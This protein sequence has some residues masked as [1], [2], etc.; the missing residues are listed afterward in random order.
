MTNVTENS[1]FDLTGQVAFV[2]GAGGG[3]GRAIAIA[4]GAA[5]AAVVCGDLAISA[6]QHTADSV[7]GQAEAV[8]LD[9]RDRH[10]FADIVAAVAERHGR[11][12]VMCNVAGIPGNHANVADLDE[13]EIDR[14]IAVNLKGVLFGCQAAL[15]A[16]IPMGSGSIINMSSSAIDVA[17]PGLA[18]YTM[19]K[20]AV[21]ALTKVFATEAGPYG[22][23]VNAVAPGWVETPLAR[24]SMTSA[25]GIV[26]E[27]ALADMMARMRGL[28]PLGRVGSPEDVANAFLYL[29]SPA[30]AFVTGQTL[31][32]NGGASMPW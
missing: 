3:L 25:D 27:V 5:G 2:T 30:S 4:F 14:V 6:A 1:A 13:D 32:P 11:L 26:D 20:A 29:A 18:T 28:S 22:I 12:D 10:E 9:V 19:T 16:M 31:R 15:R 17:S 24:S 23:R 21:A 8:A 7:G